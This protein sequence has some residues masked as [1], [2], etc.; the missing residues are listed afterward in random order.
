MKLNTTI[1]LFLDLLFEVSFTLV[2]NQISRIGFVCHISCSTCFCAHGV[3][4][5]DTIFRRLL[6]FSSSGKNHSF[7]VEILKAKNGFSKVR[8]LKN[9]SVY[10]NNKVVSENIWDQEIL[11]R[12]WSKFIPRSK[13]YRTKSLEN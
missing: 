5:L 11:R 7:P 8:W 13:R 9:S 12:K 4:V 3:L 10:F 6:N 2:N 1:L